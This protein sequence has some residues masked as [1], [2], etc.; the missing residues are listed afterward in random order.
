MHE[1]GHAV[2]SVLLGHPV[3]K[4]ARDGVDNLRKRHSKAARMREIVVAT[5]GPASEQYWF[6]VPMQKRRELWREHWH[7]DAGNIAKHLATLP[8]HLRKAMRRALT[9][10][11]VHLVAKYRREIAVVA[12]ALEQRGTLTGDDV[13]KIVERVAVRKMVA[14]RRARPYRHED[15]FIAGRSGASDGSM[16]EDVQSYFDPRAGVQGRSQSPLGSMR[17]PGQRPP[18]NLGDDVVPGSRLRVRGRRRVV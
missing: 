16:D 15:E 11:A 5:C 13:K 10:Q 14:Y 9:K 4:V 17:E 1:A 12:A 3:V 18:L 8:P 6:P 2:A 7:S